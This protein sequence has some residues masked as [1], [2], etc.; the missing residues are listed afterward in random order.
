[1]Y[2]YFC[3]PAVHLHWWSQNK[4]D[5][6]VIYALFLFDLLKNVTN[7]HFL[8]F[9]V[10]FFFSCFNFIYIFYLFY[11]RSR[12]PVIVLYTLY[13]NFY[14]LDISSFLHV[15]Y[16]YFV[17]FCFPSYFTSQ[18]CFFPITISQSHFIFNVDCF[19]LESCSAFVVI[20][21]HQSY[22]YI[23]QIRI[24]KYKL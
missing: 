12:I 7:I 16:K 6:V 9:F 2:I 1:M 13:H 22:I 18:R 19:I 11:L 10:C 8:S 5:G 24:P 4:F 3:S 15:G 17:S 20:V 23:L 21:R 14:V